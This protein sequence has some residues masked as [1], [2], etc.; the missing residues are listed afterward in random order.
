MKIASLVVLIAVIFIP[1]PAHA[2]LNLVFP[3]ELFP[4]GSS[5]AAAA[6]GDVNNDGRNDVVLVSGYSFHPDTDYHIHV[7]L[8]NSSGQLAVPVKYPTSA[9]YTRP[10]DS[11][12][13]GDVNNDGRSDVV[14]GM[15]EGAVG[16][17][18]HIDVFL[19]NS[20]GGFDAARTYTSINSS[21]IKI[22]DFN[23]DGLL[24]VAGKR[25][26]TG[27]VDV[28]LQ[29][30]NGTLG[31][32]V[33]YVSI[34]DIYTNADLSAGDLNNDG[35]TDIVVLNGPN[36]GVLLQQ[37]SG[38]LA[39]PV[40]YAFDTTG[41]SY[42][43]DAGDVNGDGLQDVVVAHGADT[44][45]GRSV[46][47]FFQNDM[48][49]LEPM[50]SYGTYGRSEY[51]HI[52]DM[53]ND[54]KQDLI[55]QYGGYSGLGYFG[56]FLQDKN[57]TLMPE[58]LYE[59][60]S[61]Y[62][63]LSGDI[64]GDGLND[65]VM[66]LYI[67]LSDGALVFYHRKY[68]A[69]I[70]EVPNPVDFKDV[71]IGSAASQTVVIYNTGAADLDVIAISIAGQDSS[72]F[73][74]Q[75]DN[76][77]GQSLPPL[78]GCAVDIVFSPSSTGAKQASLEI[79]SNDPD[80]EI[81]SVGLYGNL[82]NNALFRSPYAAFPISKGWATAVA[83]GDV[84]SDGRNDAV[85]AASGYDSSFHV[86]LQD[87][88]GAL[89]PPVAYTTGGGSATSVDIGDVNNDGKNDVVVGN[90]ISIMVY[91]Q[92]SAEG[93]E[94]PMVYM[95]DNNQLRIGDFSGDGRLD[96]ASIPWGSQNDGS[97][98]YVD[99]LFQNQDGALN[100]P[101]QYYIPHGGYDEIVAGDANNDGLTDIIVMSG[102]AWY[103]NV[104][105]LIQQPDG[106]LGEPMYY[107]LGT[108]ELTR[109][110]AAGDI[111]GDAMTDIVV[112]NG[113]QPPYARIAGFSPASGSFLPSLSLSSDYYGP[114]DKVAIAD[115]N[116]DGKNDI[117][118]VH[119][120]MAFGVYLQDVASTFL[121]EE[122][123]DTAGATWYQSGSLAVGDINGDGLNDLLLANEPYGLVVHY[124]TADADLPLK[125]LSPNGGEHIATGS[126]YTV[127]WTAPA[128]AKKF[129]LKYSPDNGVTWKLIEKSIAGT[130]YNWHVLTQ[131]KNRKDCLLK[132]I[133][134]DDS[135]RI[136][137]ADRSDAPFTIEVVRVTAPDGMEVWTSGENRTI[138]WMTNET[139]A[140]VVKVKLFYTKNDGVTWLP[141][142]TITGNNSGTYNWK[143]P[144]V[145]KNKKN[146][147]VKVLL[148]DAMGNS[149]GSDASDRAF[150]IQPVPL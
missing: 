118:V 101:V 43:I 71:A 121:P 87:S 145:P 126:T 56:I 10:P 99:I 131:E 18:S 29:N 114:P 36:I 115:V 11:I 94:P 13:I 82:S 119:G 134:Y 31:P 130:A 39:P 88:T 79:S 112:T 32:P 117:V 62:Y 4:I 19:Q 49:T 111:N 116:L 97:H 50:I 91:L 85:I 20:S 135:N 58:E 21:I 47:I 52:A 90:G 149:V 77:T 64:N 53:N 59:S 48:G 146:C 30:Q 45:E 150:T 60:G 44:P 80:N 28:L 123:Y 106:S 143:V 61:G 25:L 63:P 144:G 122:M 129:T 16:E 2:D 110:I 84:N 9:S 109:G 125:L 15:T 108:Y 27:S 78:F 26:N 95:L 137:G 23:G 3:P 124:H 139:I 72:Q 14:V 133:A 107:D 12:D 73:L 42:G 41:E 132:V 1:Y 136:T 51:V 105:V 127:Q 102:Q 74:T 81:L 68:E 17:A 22:G 46:G 7:L 69:E 96:V 98:A 92:N 24:D 55:V 120:G 37:E 93:F 70:N 138:T 38:T 89:N 67:G 35:L 76:C 142:M 8:Q 147:R 83:I 140:P 65:L 5:P 54:G 103:P 6:I 40:V 100:P 34:P 86:F 75:Y 148:K 141:I 66:G 128:A 104:S 113:E 57:G 33:T